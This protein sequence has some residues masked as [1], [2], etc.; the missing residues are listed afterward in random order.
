MPRL[1]SRPASR[2]LLLSAALLFVL[3]VTGCRGPHARLYRG[4][5]FDAPLGGRPT[6]VVDLDGT[7]VDGARWA[8]GLVDPLVGAAPPFPDAPAALG[9]LARAHQIVF[10]T[11][12]PAFTSRATL[13]WL[14]AHGFPRAPVVFAYPFAL[15]GRM[16]RPYKSGVIRWLMHR[17]RP[18]AWGIG[19]TATDMSAY[20]VADMASVRILEDG[21]EGNAGASRESP[22]Y[23][24]VGPDTAWRRIEGAIERHREG[25]RLP[26]NAPARAGGG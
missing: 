21:G 10:V 3:A 2:T 14:D 13:Q 20:A 25:A 7:V 17:Q 8:R 4:E 11:A 15:G 1:P 18:L 5:S 23:F 12:R 9:R 22:P 26:G 16:Q 19:D 6:L 24:E